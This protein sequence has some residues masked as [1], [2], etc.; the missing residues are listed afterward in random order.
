M[1]ELLFAMLPL[2][3]M[4]VLQQAAKHNICW[5]DGDVS[6]YGVVFCQQ[7]AR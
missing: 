2:I 5:I 7:F 1:L 4:L 3:A 6:K